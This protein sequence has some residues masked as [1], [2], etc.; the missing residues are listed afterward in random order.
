MQQMLYRHPT[1]V[2]A[3]RRTAPEPLAPSRP[4]TSTCLQSR[5]FEAPRALAAAHL[6]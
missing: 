6:A 4:I 3:Q 2:K 5:A 1:P